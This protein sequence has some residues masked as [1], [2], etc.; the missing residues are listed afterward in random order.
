MNRIKTMQGDYA[1]TLIKSSDADVAASWIRE[2]YS[3]IQEKHLKHSITGCTA[4]HLPSGLTQ[5]FN[6]F[7]NF[8]KKALLLPTDASDAVPFSAPLRN[9]DV[10]TARCFP[11]SITYVL[12]SHVIIPHTRS[13]RHQLQITYGSLHNTPCFV[14]ALTSPIA[15]IKNPGTKSS[16]NLNFRY[17]RGWAPNG[18]GG[19]NRLDELGLA[20]N[21]SYKDSAETAVIPFRTST[22]RTLILPS[23]DIQNS[24][25]GSSI[26]P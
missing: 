18:I 16:L 13:L 24:S 19:A 22:D 2:Q 14:N 1:N 20:L 25:C 8:P 7:S 6:C 10:N 3:L 12:N 23:V 17:Q 15:G 26:I 9:T 4:R 21:I 5:S 11:A